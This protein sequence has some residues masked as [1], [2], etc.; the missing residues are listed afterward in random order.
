MAQ[1]MMPLATAVWL[2]DNTALTFEQIAEFCGMH[3]LEVTAIADGEVGAGIIGLDPVTNGQLDQ[4]DIERCTKDASAH[5]VLKEPREHLPALAQRARY[6]PVSKR[7]DKPNAIA[8]LVQHDSEPSN[9]QISKLLG[10]TKATIEAVR[11]HTHWN[12]ANIRPRDPVAL[13]LC[14]QTDLNEAIARAATGKGRRRKATATAA[15]D[16][17]DAADRGAPADKG[18]AADKGAPADEGE[19]ES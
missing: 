1:P 10:T 16:K 13:G 11:N 19:A 14:S 5:L 6:T 12:S 8:W 18:E 7:A 9:A 2:V 3:P 15:A 4:S 17:G